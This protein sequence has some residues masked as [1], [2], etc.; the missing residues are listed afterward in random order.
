MKK[1]SVVVAGTGQIRA[2][3]FSLAP[4]QAMCSIN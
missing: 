1:L 4:L 2:W 3:R